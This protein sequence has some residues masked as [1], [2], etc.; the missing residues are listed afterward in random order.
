MVWLGRCPAQRD[1]ITTP[2]E[3]PHWLSEF[4]PHSSILVVFV[5]VQFREFVPQ[6][7]LLQVG[8][9]VSLFMSDLGTSINV[10]FHCLVTGDIVHRNTCLEWPTAV[11]P[12]VNLSA[13]LEVGKWVCLY[14]DAV[15]Q[16]F[17]NSLKRI[18]QQCK[19]YLI[20]LIKCFIPPLNVHYASRALSYSILNTSV[21]K[22]AIQQERECLCVYGEG[23][24]LYS[25]LMHTQGM[26]QVTEL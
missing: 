14:N 26:V 15:Y 5:H 3:G 13:I 2:V 20:T 4:L 9:V 24:L 10:A 6:F 8:A 16:Y 23:V 7:V 21:S 17:G 18:L 25:W 19:A 1:V 12:H 11:A 22:K